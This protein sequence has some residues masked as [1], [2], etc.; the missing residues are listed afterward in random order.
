MDS[1]GFGKLRDFLFFLE[2]ESLDYV[3][4]LQVSVSD[5]SKC[6]GSR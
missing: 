1:G 2:T 3:L 4:N 5:R 6:I